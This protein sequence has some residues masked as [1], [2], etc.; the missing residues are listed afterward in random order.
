MRSFFRFRI[1]TLLLTILAVSIAAGWIA[2]RRRLMTKIEN[3]N[4]PISFYSEKLSYWSPA[5]Y[6][7]GDTES[8]ESELAEV[9]KFNGD[10]IVSS[11]GMGSPSLRQPDIKTLDQTIAL[12]NLQDRATR[13]SAVKLLALYMQAVS[14]SG[15]LDPDSVATRV[16]FQAVG[17]P[18]V[19]QLLSDA[20]PDV[21]AASALILGNSLYDRDTIELMKRTFDSEHDQNVKLHLAWAYWKIGHNYDK[22]EFYV[23]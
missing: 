8:Y 1:A 16:H 19:R 22:A 2:D 13:V 23:K 15:N 20:D 21:R 7:G 5:S 9:I 3:E 14:G 10:M 4:H 12:T 17:L 18:K 11:Q 6:L